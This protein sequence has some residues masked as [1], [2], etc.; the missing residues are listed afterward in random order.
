MKPGWLIGE[1]LWVEEDTSLRRRVDKGKMLVLLPK[2]EKCSW[3]VNVTVSLK[4]DHMLVSFE[5]LKD[6]LGLK[7]EDS[8][9]FFNLLLDKE[10]LDPQ[11]RSKVD[12]GSEGLFCREKR[13]LAMDK[14][15]GQLMGDRKKTDIKQRKANVRGVNSLARKAV[16]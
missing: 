14:D 5:W 13:E 2:V 11:Y 4:E 6:F 12:L 9:K 8:S 16:F 3:K 10:V 7:V 15:K 1:P